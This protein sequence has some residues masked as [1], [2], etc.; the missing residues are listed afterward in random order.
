MNRNNID[1]STNSSKEKNR[2]L[3]LI[4]QDLSERLINDL[5]A[6]C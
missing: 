2:D 4:I 5:N 1:K 3:E 6:G